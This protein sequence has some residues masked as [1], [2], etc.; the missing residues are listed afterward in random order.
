MSHIYQLIGSRKIKQAY[1]K[2]TALD[3][4]CPANIDSS[5]LNNIIWLYVI[6]EIINSLRLTSRKSLRFAAKNDRIQFWL[7]LSF[8]FYEIFSV[9]HFS[10]KTYCK[11]ISEYY[12]GQI[13]RI[14]IYPNQHH[15][16]NLIFMRIIL[17]TTI[18]ELFVN[19]A[20]RY[21]WNIHLNIKTF[22]SLNYKTLNSCLWNVSLYN[23]KEYVN[24]KM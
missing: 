5:V 10:S 17:V 22:Q 3:T 2:Y 20:L 9:L 15:I 7:Y 21:E 11:M 23:C 16:H 12:K 8:W 13:L 14:S 1:H 4:N 6:V 18:I 24:N 19:N